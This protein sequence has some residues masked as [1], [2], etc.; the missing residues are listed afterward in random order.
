MTH[1][2]YLSM[3]WRGKYIHTPGTGN[4]QGC[5]TLLSHAANIMKIKH[6]NYRGYNIILQGMI[7]REVTVRKIYVPT[8]FLEDKTLF[9]R[10]VFQDVIEWG[11]DVVIGGDFNVTFS[12]ADRFKRGATPGEERLEY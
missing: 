11:E 4:S 10:T 8:G 6:Y 7:E 3:A 12:A 2:K 9:F 1:D 5:I